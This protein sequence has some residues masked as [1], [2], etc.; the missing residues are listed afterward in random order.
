MILSTRCLSRI[1]AFFLGG[2]LLFAPGFCVGEA[3]EGSSSQGTVFT[4][5]VYPIQNL[6]GTAVPLKA[7]RELLV[8]ELERKGLRVLDE[9]SLDLF[10]TKNRIRYTSGV[11]AATMTAMKKETGV[12][13]VLITSLEM[14]SESVPPKIALTSRLVSTGEA[15]RIL[16][17]DGV[18][19]AG[20][21]APGILGI[22]LIE[23]PAI[24]VNKAMGSLVGS[25]ARGLGKGDGAINRGEP[26]NKFSPRSAYRSP[27]LDGREK[28]RVAII[29]FFNRTDSRDAGDIMALRFL[30]C[31][32]Q[33]GEFE[34]IEPGLI[35]AVFLDLRIIMEEGV[36]LS[37]ATALFSAL[38]VDMIVGGRVYEYYDYQGVY[39]KP[40]V[41][42]SVQLLDRAGGK[43]VWSSHS[44]NEGD[45]GVFF[46]DVG[47]VNTAHTMSAKMVR[48]IGE[49]IVKRQRS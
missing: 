16:W 7:I 37:E 36:S 22:G 12:G 14:Y 17:A 40:K 31:L 49:M 23:D 1:I 46:F 39:G 25:L 4:V 38:D 32:W 15:P 27:L 42:F 44:H 3:A 47:R 19:M 6:S 2:I 30:A 34:V 21:D 43:V 41:D 24:L 35:R 5:A 20:D 26:P 8:R 48:S 33:R 9:A 45:D 13:A 29:P 11:D 10:M 28:H 18:G